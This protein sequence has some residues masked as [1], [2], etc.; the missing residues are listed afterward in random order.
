MIKFYIF[1]FTSFVFTS[2]AYSTNVAVI[3]INYLINNSKHFIEISE[4][5]DNA[6]QEYKVKLINI[7]QKI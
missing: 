2:S 4:K 7:E 1:I 3:D 5:I 6:Q